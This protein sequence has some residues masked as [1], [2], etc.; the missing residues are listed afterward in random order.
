M[1]HRFAAAAVLAC[2]AAGLALPPPALAVGPCSI[3]R[4]WGTGDTLTA[5]D[6]TSSFTTVGVTNMVP[7]CVDD[8]S[9]DVTQMRVTTTPGTVGAESLAT[10]LAGE[11]ERIRYVIKN[12]LGISQWYAFGDNLDL[13]ARNLT[14]TGTLTAATLTPTNPIIVA[15]GGTGVATLTSNGVLYGN[16]TGNVSVTA[17]GGSNTVLTAN[18]GAPAFSATPTLT[19]VT[20]TGAVSAATLTVGSGTSLTKILSATASLDFTAL[21]AN[22]CEV[23]TVT[24]TGAADGDTVALGVP[25]ALAD[26]DGATERTTF[27]GWVSGADTVSVRR[28]NV[29]GSSTAEPAA[30][31]VRATVWKF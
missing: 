11:L 8:H 6:L 2:L 30:A 31:T 28:C 18:A 15:K 29:T 1:I 14:T 3:F 7:T 19:S 20:T 9:T 12:T 22:S 17:Q 5:S 23:L 21:A 27:F 4:S 24:V 13:G 10:T 25:T 26:V 16:G